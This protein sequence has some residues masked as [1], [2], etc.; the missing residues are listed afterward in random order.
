[1]VYI[2]VTL[3]DLHS[4]C[5]PDKLQYADTII[6]IIK[7]HPVSLYQHA[8]ES[9]SH[10]VLHLHVIF[11]SK[12]RYIDFRPY[13]K[14]GHMLDFQILPTTM[15]LNRASKYLQKAP[16]NDYEIEQLQYE[17]QIEYI[18]DYPFI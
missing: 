4:N 5:N 7:D 6:Q 12:T 1:M 14:A 2:L 10:K 13:M 3:K 8:W 17:R 18:S 9:D 11:K 15:D 16:L